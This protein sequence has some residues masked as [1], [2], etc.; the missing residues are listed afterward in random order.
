MS[1]FQ[2]QKVALLARA[3]REV[4]ELRLLDSPR[5]STRNKTGTAERIFIK[6]DTGVF[7]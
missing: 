4:A 3:Q 2:R 7:Y 1:N 5:L 6:F